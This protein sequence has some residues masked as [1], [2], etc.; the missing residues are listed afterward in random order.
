MPADWTQFA[1]L[2]TALL[3]R[4]K[5]AAEPTILSCRGPCP[6]DSIQS[7]TMPVDEHFPSL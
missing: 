2:L 3:Y 7:D 5:D 6:K 4:I 1:D